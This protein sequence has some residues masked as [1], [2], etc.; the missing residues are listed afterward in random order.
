MVASL[1]RGGFATKAAASAEA[2]WPEIEGTC[3][4]VL[5]DGLEDQDALQFLRAVTRKRSSLPVVAVLPRGDGARV[6]AA[7]R[8]GARGCLYAAAARD[9]LLLA[10]VEALEGGHPMSSGMAPLF[11]EHIRSSAR[12]SSVTFAVRPLTEREK[13][14]LGHMARGLSY[15]ETG[16]VLGVSLNTIRTYVRGIYEKLDVESRTEAVLL[17]IKLGLIK[18]TPYPGP[19]R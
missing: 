4:V 2:A 13:V 1:G 18:G 15:A 16:Q 9:G 12:R 14:V 7:V 6:V 11:L 8:A 5:V 3:G 19:L 17:G 10:M